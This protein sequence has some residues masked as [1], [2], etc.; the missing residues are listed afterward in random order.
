MGFQKPGP[1]ALAKSL[2]A[3]KLNRFIGQELEPIDTNVSAEY[4]NY[5]V[6][7]E[8]LSYELLDTSFKS[9]PKMARQ[10]L[11]MELD[12]WSKQTCLTLGVMANHRMFLGHPCCQTLLA[13]LW[14][15]AL[16]FKNHAEL[17]VVLG[18]VFPFLI[19]LWDFKSVQ[20]LKLLPYQEEQ[21]QGEH[22]GF[23]EEHHAGS[24]T[25]VRSEELTLGIF[26]RSQPSITSSVFRSVSLK[27]KLLKS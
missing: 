21:Q 14:M 1:G 25:S 7:W 26:R 4:N 23:D 17:K 5:A 13:D 18:I 27:I 6:E 22:E 16:N 11:T 9:D 19:F 20:E 2:I 8:T 12:E 3:V 24:T 10:L 15:G